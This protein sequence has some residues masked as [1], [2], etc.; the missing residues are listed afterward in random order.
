MYIVQ[1]LSRRKP[2]NFE[3]E[4]EGDVVS[5]I[6]WSVKTSDRTWNE[7]QGSGVIVLW[8]CVFMKLQV[9]EN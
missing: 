3:V 8:R 6:E 7:I 2:S 4:F 9:F 5:L 1:R